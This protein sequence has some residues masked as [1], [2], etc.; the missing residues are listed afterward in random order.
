MLLFVQDLITFPCWSQA[1]LSGYVLKISGG[2]LF[3]QFFCTIVI[4]LPQGMGHAIRYAYHALKTAVR[5]AV[6]FGPILSSLSLILLALFSP[7]ALFHCYQSPFSHCLNTSIFTWGKEAGLLLKAKSSGQLHSELM[8]WR[9]LYSRQDLVVFCLDNERSSPSKRWN[10]G[11]PKSWSHRMNQVVLGVG[12][13]R[14][15]FLFLECIYK[16]QIISLLLKG[17]FALWNATKLSFD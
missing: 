11:E 6:W 7:L 17:I 2:W 3:D 4:A 13:N 16:P 10:G 5:K 14:D 12:K 8:V 15:C 9:N 1:P